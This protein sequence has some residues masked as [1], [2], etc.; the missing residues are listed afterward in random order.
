M[1][2]GSFTRP[3]DFLQWVR[4]TPR[5]WYFVAWLNVALVVALVS[6]VGSRLVLAPG[7]EVGLPAAAETDRMSVGRSLVATVT[8]SEVVYF[9]GRR[10]K[11]GEFEARLKE[12]VRGRPEVALLLRADAELSV[13]GL[14]RVSDAAR[15][16]GV[17]R[18]QLAAPQTE[19][20]QDTVS[21]V[22]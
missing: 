16:A 14:L 6:V 4:P 13:G 17:S 12:E 20:G 18:L 22:R 2:P 7:L 19:P 3:F 15:R 10:L 1:S 5:R 21:E 9:S 11:L 8:R